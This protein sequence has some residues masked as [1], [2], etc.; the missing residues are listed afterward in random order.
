M[1][2]V[3]VHLFVIKDTMVFGEVLLV[4]QKNSHSTINA[5]IGNEKKPDNKLKQQ[6]LIEEELTWNQAVQLMLIWKK[7]KCILFVQYS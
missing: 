1:F 2:Y 5:I 3:E 6:I 4:Y 7:I